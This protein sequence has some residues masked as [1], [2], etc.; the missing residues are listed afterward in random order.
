M[1]KL[2]VLRHAK[3]S[4]ESEAGTDFD[5]PLNGRGREA[6]PAMGREM[7]RRD[8]FPDLVIA[9]PARR[10]VETLDGIVAGLG[11]PLDIR[12]DERLYLAE[13]AALVEA[14]RQVG[15]AGCVMVAGHNP[16]LQQLVLA[17][18]SRDGG[19][20]QEVAAKFPTAAL[21]EIHFETADWHGIEPGSGRLASFIRPRN[22][23]GS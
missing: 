11:R 7:A 1:K 20:R 2:L 12:F 10:V 21:A 16:G 19:A 23:Q 14:I 8:L 13:P 3:S 18:C 22:L 5:R 17:L 6:A 9:S 15:D 4:W